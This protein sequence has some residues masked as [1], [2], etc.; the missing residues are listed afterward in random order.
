MAGLLV[1]G[2]AT[3]IGSGEPTATPTANMTPDGLQL[4]APPSYDP[5]VGVSQEILDRFQLRKAIEPNT[6]DR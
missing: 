2:C 1:N 6:A 3:D 5:C 4:E